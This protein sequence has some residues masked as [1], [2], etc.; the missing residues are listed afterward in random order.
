MYFDLDVR[1]KTKLLNRIAFVKY[2]N[3]PLD[4]NKPIP[5]QV[6]I[7]T[8]SMTPEASAD[9]LNVQLYTDMIQ[10]NRLLYAP[11]VRSAFQ[12]SNVSGTEDLLD[13]VQKR[14][15]D[16]DL[17]LENVQK[18]T[19][20]PTISLTVS[21]VLQQASQKTSSSV[22][23]NHIDK[24]NASQVD[25][26]M[27]E[28]GL[29]RFFSDDQSNE[30]FTVEVSE[31]VKNWPME[32][33]RQTRSVDFPFP[34]SVEKEI[35]FW[36]DLEKKLAHTK[37]QLEDSPLLLTKLVLKRV[38]KVAEQLVQEAEAN[39]ATAQKHTDV[40]LQFLREFPVEELVTQST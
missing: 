34:G 20:I 7:S 13:L 26:C 30:T 3:Q 19:V 27:N 17:A 31:S 25:Q 6:K 21:Q 24:Y 39:L 18:G 12:A 16:L 36:E 32:I 1:M 35:N 37:T 28:L 15:R 29:S 11:L 38:N 40:S 5:P 22:L 9:E 23:S 8:M 2:G 4:L 14:M 33:S 10:T